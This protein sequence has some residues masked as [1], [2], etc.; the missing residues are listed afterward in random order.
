MDRERDRRSGRS[1]RVITL[2]PGGDDPAET[3]N[4]F[5]NYTADELIELIQDRCLFDRPT[6][7]IDGD[8]KKQ[9]TS[10]FAPRVQQDILPSPRQRHQ[11]RE[12]S[13]K[14]ESYDGANAKNGFR[15]RDS[16]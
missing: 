6:F 2:G 11:Q 13:F 5:G 15:G 1:A 14:I 4:R 7:A 8:P 9:R 3:L 16:A 10:P 12:S